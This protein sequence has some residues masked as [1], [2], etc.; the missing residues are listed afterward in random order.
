M[1]CT[2]RVGHVAFTDAIA[3]GCD[4]T[5]QKGKMISKHELHELGDCV[6]ALATKAPQTF[7]LENIG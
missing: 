2:I 3:K 6:A 4:T 7:R 1:L 5:K